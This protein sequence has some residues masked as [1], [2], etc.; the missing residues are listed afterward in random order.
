[1]TEKLNVYSLIQT[2]H[3]DNNG[4]GVVNKMCTMM[5]VVIAR[6]PKADVAILFLKPVIANLRGKKI[7]QRAEDNHKHLIGGGG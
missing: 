6:R 2:L 7:G 5:E 1:M 3:V 4:M